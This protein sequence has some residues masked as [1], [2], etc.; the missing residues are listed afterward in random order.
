MRLRENRLHT[1]YH[2]KRIIEKDNEGCTTERYD[3][4]MP[5]R[6]ECWPASG[7]VQAEQYGIRL[8]YIKNLRISEGYRIEPDK[9]GHLH[10][11]LIVALT[12]KNLME[13]VSIRQ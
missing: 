12:F 5:F 10:M 8:N 7:K 9:E 2:R 3:L 11:F 1:Y 13:S 4:D 6:G